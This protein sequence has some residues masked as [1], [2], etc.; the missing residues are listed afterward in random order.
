MLSLVDL[1][2]TVDGQFVQGAGATGDQAV[3]D[4]T[5]VV[6]EVLRLH[7]RPRLRTD[8]ADGRWRVGVLE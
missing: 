6:N 2:L 7:F 3:V 1:F 8:G 5:Q 4:Q